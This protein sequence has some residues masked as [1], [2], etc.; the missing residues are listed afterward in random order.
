MCYHGRILKMFIDQLM[1]KYIKVYYQRKKLLI[2]Y[3]YLHVFQDHFFRAMD[4]L[5]EFY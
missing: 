2:F 1:M 5:E 4:I 3:L